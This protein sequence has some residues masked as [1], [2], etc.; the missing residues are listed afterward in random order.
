MSS[1][2]RQ[3]GLNFGDTMTLTPRGS[4]ERL[5]VR[6]GPGPVAYS[7]R[8]HEL[9]EDRGRGGY[10]SHSLSPSASVMFKPRDDMTF[11]GTF[12]GSVQ[13]PDVAG[14]STR[15]TII[16]NASQALPPYRSKEGEIGYKLRCVRSASPPRCSASS[17][18]SR[19]MSSA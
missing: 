6:T 19:I 12:A 1:I 7:D 9:P 2:I 17:A 16:V 10:V 18:R 3:Q 15:N 11:Y 4:H 8:R 5:S 14:S 13:A